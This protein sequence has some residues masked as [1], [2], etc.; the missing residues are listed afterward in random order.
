ML[1]TNKQGANQPLETVKAGVSDPLTLESTEN[2]QWATFTWAQPVKVPPEGLWAALVVNR[3]EVFHE[4]AAAG[5]NTSWA[6]VLWGAPSGPWRDL[7]AAL[8]AQR[9][10]VRLIGTPKSGVKIDPYRISIGSGP[11]AGFTPNPKGVAG[12]L[13]LE[14]PAIQTGP[15]ELVITSHVPAALKLRDVEV[16]SAN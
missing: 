9:G 13:T 16:V 10:R 5:G 4:F 15:A 8:V 11:D 12:A 14:Q 7:P 6:T 2:A 1:W 3:G